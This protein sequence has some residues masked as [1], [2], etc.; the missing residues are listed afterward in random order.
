[1][2]WQSEWEQTL[3]GMVTKLFFP[4]VKHRLSS[5][6][7]LS[8]NFTTMVTGHGRLRAYYCRFKIKD[9][10]I[11]VC[12]DGDQTVEHLLYAV[13]YTHLAITN[14]VT[15]RACLVTD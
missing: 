14:I 3:N 4:S 9:D 11:C 2:E 6:F 10:P 1:M 7:A 15:S 8:P 12:N 5:R 13:S